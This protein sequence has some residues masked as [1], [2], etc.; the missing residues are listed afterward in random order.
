MLG[1]DNPTASRFIGDAAETFRKLGYWLIGLTPRPQNYFELEA[2]KAMW[3]VADN[4]I[5]LQMSADNVDYLAKHSGLIDEAN[6]EI[7]QSLRTKRGSH[8]DVYYLN[9]KKTRQGAFRY[10]QT[11]LDRGLA[12]TNAKDDAV[13]V[14]AL[15]RFKDEKWKALEFLARTYPH[16]AQAPKTIDPC[17]FEQPF[18]P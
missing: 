9:K 11:P 4:F 12:P 18:Q 14:K 10:F 5:F 1:R 8:A 2:G 13:A 7:I 17:P 15:H 16:G 6:R 3:G